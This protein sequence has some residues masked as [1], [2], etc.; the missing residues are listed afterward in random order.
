MKKKIDIKPKKKEL[1]KVKEVVVGGVVEEAITG[2]AEEVGIL[3]TVP[4]GTLPPNDILEAPATQD[5]KLVLA[6]KYEVPV[7]K[8]DYL[9]L[10]KLLKEIGANSIGDLEVRASKL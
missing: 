8:E 1:K 7:T 3:A 2:V 9:A 4:E 5:I 6:K 10:H